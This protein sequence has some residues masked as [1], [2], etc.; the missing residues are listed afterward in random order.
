MRAFVSLTMTPTDAV[1]A[2]PAVLPTPIVAA[3]LMTLSR[4][5]ASTMTS[6]FALTIAFSA[7]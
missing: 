4:A 5:L 6:L 7:I 1:P 2:T 3:E